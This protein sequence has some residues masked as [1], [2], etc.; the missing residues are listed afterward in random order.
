MTPLAL[1]YVTLR[2]FLDDLDPET[3]AYPDATLL[4]ALR[5]ALLLNK[6]PGYTLT[7]DQNAVT[8]DLLAAGANPNNYALLVYHTV[9]LFHLGQRDRYSY[10]TRAVSESFGSMREALL[11]LELDLHQLENGTLFLSW[12]SYHS[13]VAGM[14]G[15]PAGLVLTNVNVKAPFFT[16]N[17]STAGVTITPSSPTV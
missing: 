4:N 6:L 7:P 9:R 8:P 14:A 10:K 11:A 5:A 3:F 16:A 15:L 17:V 2:V 12:Q 13:W 1:F